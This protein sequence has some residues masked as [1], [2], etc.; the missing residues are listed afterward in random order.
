MQVKELNPGDYALIPY[1]YVWSDHEAIGGRHDLSVLILEGRNGINLTLQCATEKGDIIWV[2]SFRKA[3]PTTSFENTQ[4]K[5]DRVLGEITVTEKEAKAIIAIVGAVGGTFE[6]S[7]R[8]GFVTL[9]E[10]LRDLL[11]DNGVILEYSS[12]KDFADFSS[13]G[14]YF[15][16]G[17]FNG[18]ARIS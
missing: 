12:S 3:I 9:A 11:D 15:K 13:W 6:N 17:V 10:K 16:E 1:S 18:D 2:E 7:L 5:N 4:S 8:G 14:V